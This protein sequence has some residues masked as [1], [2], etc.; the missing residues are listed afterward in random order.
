ME[1]DG[2][3]TGTTTTTTTSDN[4]SSPVKIRTRGNGKLSVATPE[5]EQT[6]RCV[7]PL[8][9]SVRSSLELPHSQ[10]AVRSYN[11]PDLHAQLAV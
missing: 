2:E 6:K 7:L 10:P 9:L 3:E 8:D 11:M 1:S 5:R 4:I